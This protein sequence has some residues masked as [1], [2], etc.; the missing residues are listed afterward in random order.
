MIVDPTAYFTT[1]FIGAD[2]SGQFDGR[3]L[4]TLN[5]T[6]FG[7][8]TQLEVTGFWVQ[9]ILGTWDSEVTRTTYYSTENVYIFAAIADSP[10]EGLDGVLGLSLSQQALLN[11]SVVQKLQA[12]PD[13]KFPKVYYRFVFE[14]LNE[15]NL[16][17]GKVVFSDVMPEGNFTYT[18]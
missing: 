14:P 15:S 5:Y 13:Y 8:D 3:L 2:F 9:V 1:I 6:N 16:I 17:R 12:D 18:G 10:N 4:R 11:V 7:S